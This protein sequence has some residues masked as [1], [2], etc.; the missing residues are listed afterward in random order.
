MCQLVAEKEL[1]F[2]VGMHNG[3]DTNFY[4]SKGYR[5]VGVEAVPALAMAAALRFREAIESTSLVILNQAIAESNGQREFWVCD[6][7]SLLS[8]LNRMMAAREGARHHAE[9]IQTRTLGSIMDEFGT[10]HY[11]KVDIEGYDQV[12][13]AQLKSRVL[14]KFISI[15]SEA[16]GEGELLD[17]D[18]SLLSLETLHQIG[19]TK[20]KLIAQSDFAALTGSSAQM[21]W[22]KVIR[23]A[24]GGRLRGLGLSRIAQ[25]LTPCWKVYAH[26]KYRFPHG[27]SGPWGN[28]TLGAWMDYDKARAAYLRSRRWLFKYERQGPFTIWCDWHATI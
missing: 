1:I 23:S 11:L 3:D 28:G 21:L 13:I 22:R 14:P 9:P 26:H 17:E 2:D 10:P 25:Q 18:H 15:E 8:S 6:D 5:V 24:A 12:C 27:S 19:Y 4:L 20:F 7:N 16:V